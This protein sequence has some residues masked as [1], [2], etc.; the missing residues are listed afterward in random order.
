MTS[1]TSGVVAFGTLS[2]IVIVAVL[3]GGLL[4]AH[5]EPIEGYVQVYFRQ[6]W[7]IIGA[8]VAAWCQLKVGIPLPGVRWASRHWLPGGALVGIAVLVE[9]LGAGL[10][11]AEAGGAT[12]QEWMDGGDRSGWEEVSLR[13]LSGAESGCLQESEKTETWQSVG[14]G[15]R[16]MGGRGGKEGNGAH[17]LHTFPVPGFMVVGT[18][19]E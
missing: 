11:Q 3:S 8:L 12:L 17:L 2:C 13:I 15:R 18:P 6:G 14:V 16:K 7:G 9:A 5:Q 4:L 19:V 10:G 1:I